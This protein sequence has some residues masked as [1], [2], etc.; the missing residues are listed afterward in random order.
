MVSKGIPT[1]KENERIKRELMNLL[2]ENNDVEKQ[3]FNK[4]ANNV[5]KPQEAICLISRYECII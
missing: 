4:A 3:G 2:K 5:L 1:K